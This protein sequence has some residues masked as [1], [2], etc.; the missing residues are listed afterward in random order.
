M[1]G[2][3]LGAMLRYT[4]TAWVDQRLQSTFP[5]G[6][7]AVNVSGCL[8]IGILATLADERGVISQNLRI[9]LLT[10]FLG[11]VTTFS[12]FGLETWRLI[13]AG[14]LPLALAN[15]LGSVGA[16]L[17]AVAGGIA[18]ARAI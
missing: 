10:G 16:C 5:W 18:I 17:I 1:A 6:T 12:S 15:S 7:L 14:R 9:F 11:A 4:L 3:A 13:E 8:V 2:G